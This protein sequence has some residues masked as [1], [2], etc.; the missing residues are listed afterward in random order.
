MPVVRYYVGC[1]SYQGR[2]SYPVRY[3]MRPTVIGS[4]V[5]KLNGKIKDVEVTLPRGIK[6]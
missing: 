5:V 4:P 1:G 2:D 6:S 3:G